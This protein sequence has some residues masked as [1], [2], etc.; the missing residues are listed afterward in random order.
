M[1][2]MEM[3]YIILTGFTRL[4]RM[5]CRCLDF[6]LLPQRRPKRQQS[7][8]LMITALLMSLS[9]VQDK[10]YFLRRSPAKPSPAKPSPST[11][12]VAGSGTSLL[13]LLLRTPLNVSTY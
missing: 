10:S 8:N 1:F 6:P 7:R 9:G 3:N 13:P 5:V 2:L 12:S 11:A 4:Y